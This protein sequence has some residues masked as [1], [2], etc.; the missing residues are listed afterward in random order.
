MTTTTIP[1]MKTFL[2]LWQQVPRA[3]GPSF[4]LPIRYVHVLFGSAIFRR[5]VLSQ[6]LYQLYFVNLTSTT[7]Q[8]VDGLGCQYGPQNGQGKDCCTSRTRS[9]RMLQT[10]FQTMS[11]G[12]CSLGTHRMR[13]DCRQVS[14]TARDGGDLHQ[15]PRTRYSAVSCGRRWTNTNCCRI[16]YCAGIGTCASVC[17]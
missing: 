9:R 3:R 11:Q 15:G 10:V 6:P 1:T 16:T 8:R 7:A 5:W 14:H 13:Q 12:P 2:A 4:M 17:F